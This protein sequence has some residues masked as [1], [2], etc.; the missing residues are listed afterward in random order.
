MANSKD[1]SLILV[2]DEDIYRDLLSDF[3][4]DEGYAVETFASGEKAL[5]R[6]QQN[7]F[8]C[9]VV[10]IRLPGIDGNQ[11]VLD[12][13]KIDPQIQVIIHTGSSDYTIPD[14]LK[15]MGIDESQLLFKPLT[16]MS[17]LTVQVDKL[18]NRGK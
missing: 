13:L 10:D 6:L 5:E 12:A 7:K 8:D 16:D 17:R 4:M 18:L 9:M 3:F 14:G 15:A 1:V 11:V 2:D